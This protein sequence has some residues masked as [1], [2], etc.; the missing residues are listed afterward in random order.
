MLGGHRLLISQPC[1]VGNRS[2]DVV[3]LVAVGEPLGGTQHPCGQARVL[4]CVWGD[5]EGCHFRGH[6]LGF[7]GPCLL[8]PLEPR[9]VNTQER[10]S[11]GPPFGTPPQNPAYQPEFRCK[12]EACLLFSPVDLKR[13]RHQRRVLR[14]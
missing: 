10:G 5:V 3:L 6:S 9:V 12:G 7:S 13:V 11:L 14:T 4:R 1:D 8:L 2:P